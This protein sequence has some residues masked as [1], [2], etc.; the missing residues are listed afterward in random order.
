MNF[1]SL[2]SCELIKL[3]NIL[4]SARVTYISRV[5]RIQLFATSLCILRSG[6]DGGGSSSISCTLDLLEFQC[7]DLFYV[8][9]LL[10]GSRR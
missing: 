4:L 9:L 7:H 5:H 3:T 1:G 2:F 6:G 8:K 10:R